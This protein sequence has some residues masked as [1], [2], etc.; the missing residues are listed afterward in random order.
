[1]K[2]ESD[3]VRGNSKGGERRSRGLF[4]LLFQ[5]LNR[6]EC[7][8]VIIFFFSN[9]GGGVLVQKGTITYASWF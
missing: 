2:C 8:L 6:L 7:T 4:K 1:M 9:G 5:N 3:W